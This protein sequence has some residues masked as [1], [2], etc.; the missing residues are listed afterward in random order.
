MIP[1]VVRIEIAAQTRRTVR[2]MYSVRRRRL[3]LGDDFE[4]EAAA[5]ELVAR[6]VKFGPS[7]HCRS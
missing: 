3:D 2:E 6:D 7:R 5:V 4:I 1:R